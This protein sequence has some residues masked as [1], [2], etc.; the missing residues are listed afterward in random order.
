MLKNNVV[1]VDSPGVGE[2]EEIKNITLGYVEKASAFVYVI[3]MMNA[4]G[5]QQRMQEFIEEVKKKANEVYGVN[6][7]KAIFVCNKW[8]EVPT[9]EKTTVIKDTV[10]R[11][12][13]LWNGLDEKQIIPFS[14]T[15]AQWIQG[16]GAVAPNFRKVL[17]KLADLIPTAQYTTTLKAQTGLGKVLE[18]SLQIAS[19]HIENSRLNEEQ[20]RVKTTEAEKRLEN[21]EEKKHV[22]ISRQREN[23]KTRI[24]TEASKI[25]D[26][27]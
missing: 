14:T 17:D 3:D 2:S 15:E 19:T 26:R 7:Q 1:I 22:F 16:Q 8:D 12:K 24:H 9:H 18:K 13:Q 23:V 21:L 27:Y 25:Y 11:L 5:V 20:L 4:G 10:E 6:L